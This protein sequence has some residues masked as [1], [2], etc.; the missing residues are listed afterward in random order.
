M[1]PVPE[2]DAIV[3]GSGP[4]AL[5]AALPLVRAGR[6]V[7]MLDVGVWEDSPA[8]ESFSRA[9]REDFNQHLYFLG[10]QFE[11]ISFGG[12]APG[13]QLTAPR[14]F[15][16]RPLPEAMPVRTEGFHFLESFARGGLA[17][18]WGAACFPFNEKDLKDFGIPLSEWLPH[19]GA[20]Q[21]N[22]GLCGDADLEFF[23][24]PLK[25]LEPPPKPDDNAAILFE[26]YLRRRER[27]NAKGFFLSR[28]WLAMG[29]GKGAAA[30][31][32]R[33]IDFWD[34][35]KGG[36]WR[37]IQTLRQLQGFSNFE[38]RPQMLVES[39]SEGDR[40]VWVSARDLSSGTVQRFFAKKLLLGAGPFGTAKIVLRSLSAYGEK[41]P[42]LCHSCLYVPMLNLPM[43]GRVGAEERHSLTQLLMIF[44]TARGSR[45][46]TLTGQLY[47]YRSLLQHRLLGNLF[48]PTRQAHRILRSLQS[49]L[50]IL[51]LHF[52]DRPHPEKYCRLL[53]EGGK[54]F[55]EIHHTPD[56]CKTRER[57]RLV[58]KILKNF[59]RLKCFGLRI[60]DPGFGASIHYAGTFP[61]TSKEK[62]LTVDHCCRLRGTQNIFLV[63]GSF[64]PNLPAKGHTFMLMANAHRVGSS[65]CR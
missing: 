64:F 42:F 51:N 34:H 40:G 29:K 52:E 36:V 30:S 22:I 17:S 28:P 56:P 32:G 12:V 58:K 19:Y 63:D 27:F 21:K 9:R 50:M 38:Y 43:L 59:R 49:A 57:R 10:P 5:F 62:P 24:P 26:N 41:V 23:F 55:L 4:G 25:N 47:S 14:R 37:P 33:D 3:V 13:A 31:A 18:A 54:D 16:V 61:M 6:A 7:L 53:Q 11:G 60:L 39:F 2:Y 44:E 46:E 15:V 45:G 1:N 35:E 48:L 65:L 20:V 8:L